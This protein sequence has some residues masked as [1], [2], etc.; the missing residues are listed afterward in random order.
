[1]KTKIQIAVIITFLACIVLICFADFA[2]VDG[3]KEYFVKVFCG[4]MITACYFIFYPIRKYTLYD[5]IKPDWC[6]SIGF[7][8][9]FDRT[10]DKAS[11]DEI[12][13]RCKDNKNNDGKLY[14]SKA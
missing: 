8:S 3:I 4:C 11:V 6:D 12:C 5:G 14:K 10:H 2:N 9:M 13:G 7:C 1:M